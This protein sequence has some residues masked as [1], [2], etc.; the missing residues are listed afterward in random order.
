MTPGGAKLHALVVDDEPPDAEELCYLLG[1]EPSFQQIDAASDAVSALSLLQ[2]N[3]YDVLFLDIQMPR[4][5]GLQLA[6]LLQHRPAVPAMV[7]VTAYEEYAL[8]A[9]EL[10][11]FDYLIKPVRRERLQQTISRL[12]RRA[13][14]APPALDRIVVD[15]DGRIVVIDV[16]NIRFA[17]AQDDRVFLATQKQRYSSRHSL[18]ELQQRLPSPPFLRTHRSYIVNLR[19][20]IEIVPFFTGSYLLRLDDVNGTQVPVSRSSAHDL[21]TLLG[22]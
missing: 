15:K 12:V 17:E 7:F 4:V 22:M 9:F 21:R 11:A 14:P 1:Q 6:Q 3:R 19:H 8:R 20:V 16:A 18:R 5:N 13:E 2:A 10:G